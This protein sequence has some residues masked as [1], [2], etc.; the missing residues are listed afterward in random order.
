MF[1][2]RIF[3]I[4]NEDFTDLLVIKNVNTH[5]SQSASGMSRLL[6]EINDPSAL[7]CNH[8]TESGC[9]FQSYRH[10]CNSTCRILL[11]VECKHLIIIHLVN[12]ISG[13]NEQIVRIVIVDKVNILS[14]CIS[15]STVYI[16][17]CI[18][19]LTRWQYKDTTVLGI[20]SPE[21]ALCCIAAK[22]HRFILGQNTNGINP[23]VGAV[24]QREIDNTILSPVIYSR[25]CYFVGKVMQTA[26]PAT[27][28]DH[29]YHFVLF[30]DISL[31]NRLV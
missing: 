25:F 4:R 26:S 8:D 5:G 21:T 1:G 12:M 14:D 20:Q 27:G 15:C 17:V 18:S 31:L 6:F 22:K 11:F 3:S 2:I 9:F 24:T 13:K 7:I 23:T 30:H 29:S 10:N 16:K 28:K 19:L